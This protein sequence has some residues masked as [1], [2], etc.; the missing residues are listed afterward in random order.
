MNCATFKASNDVFKS[1]IK[2]LR[3]PVGCSF[4]HN[5]RLAAHYPLHNPLT[6]FLTDFR[7]L[8]EGSD[9]LFSDATD[10][11]TQSDN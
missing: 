1:V 5:D 9:G 6:L 11:L 10:A 7:R 8:D 4:P 3:L 2:K